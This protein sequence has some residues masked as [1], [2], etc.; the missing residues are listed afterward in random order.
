M[1]KSAKR[2]TAPVSRAVDM[3]EDIELQN[4][5][6]EQGDENGMLEMLSMLQEFQKRK[7]SK[8]STRS[9][10]FQTKKNALFTEVRKN[11][12][13]IVREGAVYID[14]CKA[15]LAELKA[16]EISQEKNLQ[17]LS[18]LWQNQEDTVRSLLKTYPTLIEDL[19]HRRA[20]QTNDAS[21]M[22]EAHAQERQESRKRLIHLA[23]ARADEILERQKLATDATA[24]IKHYKALLLV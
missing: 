9:V 17:D 4:D 3:D 7:A 22:V 2:Q 1:V 21:E 11:V 15:R 20:A 5:E 24:F 6:E 18:A 23:K 16:Q 14:Q 8:T 13:T 12:D 19:S 10:A